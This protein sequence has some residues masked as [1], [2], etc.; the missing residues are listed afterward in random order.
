MFS[1]P[2]PT[3]YF[4]IS[5]SERGSGSTVEKQEKNILHLEAKTLGLL[6]SMVLSC[7]LLSREVLRTIDLE[8]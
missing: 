4:V 3:F 8:D 2:L 6:N 5:H 1:F 7:K